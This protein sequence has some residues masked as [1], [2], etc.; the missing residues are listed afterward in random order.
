MNNKTETSSKL[1]DLYASLQLIV[2][3]KIDQDKGL[4]V[5][6][7]KTDRHAHILKATPLKEGHPVALWISKDLPHG[8][9]TA[10]GLSITETASHTVPYYLHGPA[11]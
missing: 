8:Q 9:M 7:E 3:R 10:S 6:F 4:S 11:R 2:F 5:S 1:P